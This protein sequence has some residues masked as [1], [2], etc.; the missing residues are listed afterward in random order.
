[1]K[2]MITFQKEILYEVEILSWNCS[3]LFV[4]IVLNIPAALSNFHTCMTNEK[5]EN[6]E[7]AQDFCETKQF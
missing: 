5:C 3:S 7:L 4:N 1:M 2:A 6:Y